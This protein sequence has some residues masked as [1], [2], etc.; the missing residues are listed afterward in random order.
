M[1]CWVLLEPMLRNI[2]VVIMLFIFASF[3]PPFA[4]SAELGAGAWST[5]GNKIVD[6]EG[7]TVRITGVNWFGFETENYVVHGLWSRGYKDMMDQMKAAG[8][9]TIRLPF[10]NQIL[11][12]NRQPNGIDYAQNPDLQGL[13]SIQIM[14]KIIG[15]AGQINMKILLDRHRPTGTAQSELWYTS[16]VSETKWIDDWKTLAL[17]YKGNNTV[18]GADLHNEP[19]NAACWGCG[20]TATDWRLAAEKAGNAIHSV[21]TDW[22]IIV[23]GVQNY[24]GNNY[25][26]G[27]NLMGV[28]DYPIRLNTPNKVVYSTHD[29]PESVSG[30]P[31]FNASNYPANL[32]AIWDQYWGYIHKQNIAPVLVGEFGSKLQST[33][34]SQWFDSLI[35]YLGTGAN[36]INWT[37]WS[38]NPNSGDTGGLLQDD[39]KTLNTSKHSK[40]VPI[41]FAL[42]GTGTVAPT[43]PQPT[44]TTAPTCKYFSY[45]DANCDNQVNNSDFTIWSED[46]LSNGATKRADFNKD[47]KVS[48]I[49]FEIFIRTTF[50]GLPTL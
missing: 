15:Y 44:P 1:L 46:F 41:Q 37:F 3:V 26:W 39:W 38:W 8:Y 50:R 6:A 10:S 34:D 21:N 7:R 11:E 14:D 40:L 42:S 24:N 17:R 30:Q 2:I 35:T 49:D 9:N 29:Y 19:H 27:G 20:N 25:W 23:E 45:G 43:Q 47:G 32:P 13:T 28:K 33:K 12:Q 16:Q 18:I 4:Y 48:L 22:L 31:W 5:N 36:G